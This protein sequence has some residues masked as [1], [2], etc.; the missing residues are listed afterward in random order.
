MVSTAF[1]AEAA[2]DKFNVGYLEGPFRVGTPF[3]IPLDFLDKFGN[4]TKPSSDLKPE[5]KAK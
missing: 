3:Q 1:C 4:A 2:P 5:L